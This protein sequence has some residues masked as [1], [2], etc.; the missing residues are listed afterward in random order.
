[1]VPYERLP[2]CS[3]NASGLKDR[4]GL[5]ANKLDVVDFKKAPDQLNAAAEFFRDHSHRVKT[6]SNQLL[7]EGAKHKEI[8]LLL[9]KFLRHQQLSG[10]R[11]LSQSGV[12]EIVPLHFG[13]APAH[14]GGTPPPA[15]ATMPYFFP[16][17]PS[18]QVERKV[19]KKRDT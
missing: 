7:V 10:Y 4:Y 3:I 12:I 11:V 14:A 6:K 8:K 15:A 16:G 18:V 19:K 17:S 1:M 2:I 9:H 5:F 13:K